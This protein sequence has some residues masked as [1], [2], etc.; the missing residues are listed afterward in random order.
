M[1]IVQKH[2][3]LFI[4][5]V[6]CSWLVGCVF[7]SRPKPSFLIIAVEN[8]SSDSLDCS[9]AGNE[10][11]AVYTYGLSQLCKD[12]VRFT[13]AYTTS[14]LSQPA[15]TSV[16]T[17]LYPVDHHVHSNGGDYLSGHFRTLGEVALQQGYRTALYSGGP[18]IFRRSGLAK[19][20]EV[21]DDDVIPS[22]H[23][24]Y[25][26]FNRTIKM[27]GS[28]VGRH[29][30]QPFFA[31]IYVPDLQ[32]PTESP[33]ADS[34]ID[35]FMSRLSDLVRLLKSRRL[36]R[37][38]NIVLVGLNGIPDENRGE[39][40]TLDL[41]S[42]NTRV[43]LLFKPAHKDQDRG[44]SWSIDA[45]VSLADLGATLF[46]LLHTK[47]EIEQ[48]PQALPA[49]SLVP[50][51]EAPTISWPKNRPL[52]LESGWAQWRGVGSIR[53]AFRLGD[54]LYIHDHTPKIFDSLTDRFEAQNISP[55]DPEVATPVATIE[56]II[57]K[58]KLAPFD[59]L[60]EGLRAKVLVAEDL[61]SDDEM[62]P[63]IDDELSR[64]LNLRPSDLQIAGWLA[65][66]ALKEKDWH[67]LQRLGKY[68]HQP[69]WT[70][71]ARE[72]LGKKASLSDQVGAELSRL[73][74]ASRLNTRQFEMV[75]LLREVVRE[76]F[77]NG[78]PW[79]TIL[80]I[81]EPSRVELARTLTKYQEK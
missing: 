49:V 69:V 29:P 78:L 37:A 80:D 1:E 81:Q 59:R 64:L 79:D 66:R 31:T 72:H 18:P 74:E 4:L 61:F 50:A 73:V 77:S 11:A 17:G 24:L 14:V 19:G 71:V 62:S 23:R 21:F 43:F 28:W 10:N 55:N 47:V 2:L 48:S 39:I 7:E 76:N 58:Y 33:E 75:Q 15:L 8:L 44:N 46:D 34:Q 30:G 45:N 13:H 53:F 12:G 9:G 68:Y 22:I 20:F 63:D 56:T 60:P 32:F 41:F 6:L 40:N 54:F 57:R 25:R 35:I 51:L 42:E 3:K 26:P 67:R 65:W 5:S 16:L 70:Y 36:W 52:L 27:F 38:T